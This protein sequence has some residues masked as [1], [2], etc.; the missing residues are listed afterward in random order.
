MTNLY[1]PKPDDKPKDCMTFGQYLY[2]IVHSWGVN[3]IEFQTLLKFHTKDELRE[4]YQK[5]SKRRK[6]ELNGK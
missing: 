4:I 5:E 3:S 1:V 2:C 6:E